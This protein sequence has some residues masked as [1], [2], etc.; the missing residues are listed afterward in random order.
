MHGGYPV[1]HPNGVVMMT[2]QQMQA[3]GIPIIQTITPGG[4]PHAS[5]P[6]H[7]TVGAEMPPVS[8]YPLS[9]PRPGSPHTR[10]SEPHKETHRPGGRGR[11]EAEE[12]RG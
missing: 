7:T 9:R 8:Q 12:A 3:A 11:C 1:G 10:T 5:Y 4:S 2:P 6:V